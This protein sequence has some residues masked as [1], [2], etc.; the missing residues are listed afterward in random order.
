LIYLLKQKAEADAKTGG[1]GNSNLY[2]QASSL[3]EKYLTDTTKESELKI[4]TVTPE[5]LKKFEGWILNQVQKN[6]SP[7]YSINNGT[8]RQPW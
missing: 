6:G 8:I 4:G 1:I 5:W 7:K 3:L 2:L